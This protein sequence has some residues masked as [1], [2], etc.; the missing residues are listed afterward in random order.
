MRVNST[1]ESVLG[2]G[3]ITI[4][5]MEGMKGIGLMGDMMGMELRAGPGEVGIVGSIKKGCGM[6]S[7]YIVFIQGIAMLESG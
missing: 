1:R 2:V 6:D 5:L 4:L 7:G 3:F